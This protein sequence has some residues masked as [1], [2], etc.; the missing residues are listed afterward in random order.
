MKTFTLSKSE[1]TSLFHQD[2]AEKGS[3]GWQSL[4]VKLQTQYDPATNEIEVDPSDEERIPRYA[5]DYGNGGWEDQLTGIFGR[6]LG[7][8]LGR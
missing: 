4:M 1:E 8:R 3:G 2:P 5:F 6:H 7:A